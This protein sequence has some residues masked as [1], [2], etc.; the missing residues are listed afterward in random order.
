M[1]TR[2]LPSRTL[3][4]GQLKVVGARLCVSGLQ[5]RGKWRGR[6]QCSSSS[7]RPCRLPVQAER[8]FANS[9]WHQVFTEHQ[10]SVRHCDRHWQQCE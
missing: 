8:P 7:L 3:S 6:T 1:G 2:N 4:T 10:L 9:L 5:R